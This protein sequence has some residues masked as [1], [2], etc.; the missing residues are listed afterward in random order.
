[1]FEK[2]G[3]QTGNTR[4]DSKIL[5][6]EFQAPLALTNFLVFEYGKEFSNQN[7]SSKDDFQILPN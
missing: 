2:E 6:F 5:P 7:F 1:M 3:S 4:Q